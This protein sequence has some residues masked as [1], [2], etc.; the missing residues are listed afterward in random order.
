MHHTHALRHYVHGYLFIYL[1]IGSSHHCPPVIRIQH[2]SNLSPLFLA[3]RAF[4]SNS[5]YGHFLQI[6]KIQAPNT[7]A[8]DSSS[9]FKFEKVLQ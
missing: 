7:P 4:T 8:L 2:L 6:I 1:F 5:L 9:T 3:I